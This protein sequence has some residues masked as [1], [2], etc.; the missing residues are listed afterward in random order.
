MSRLVGF[1]AIVSFLGGCA[2]HSV[3]RRSGS[4]STAH[5]RA[6]GGDASGVWDWVFRSTD[7]QGDLRVEQEEWH[8][9]QRGT[10]I[11]G[12]YDRAVTLMS[13]DERLFRCNQRLGFTKVTRVR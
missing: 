11:E 7:D 4:A 13:T 2:T 6:D 8:L 3:A 1:F 9:E 5:A 10:R 12:W